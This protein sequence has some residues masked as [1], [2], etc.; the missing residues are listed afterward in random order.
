MATIEVDDETNRFLEF[1]SRVARISKGEV[2]ARLVAADRLPGVLDPPS[3]VLGVPVHADY[4]GY[5]T[6]ARYVPG[7]ARIEITD[8]PLAGATFKSPTAAARAVVSHYRP[9]VSAHRNGW[10][11]WTVT[12]SQVPLQNLRYQAR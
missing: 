12:A 11:F 2:V 10:S 4:A 1:A 7:P 6:R 9:T 3:P 5:R 8:G